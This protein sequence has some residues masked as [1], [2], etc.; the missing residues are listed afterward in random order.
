[1]TTLESGLTPALE[2][3]GSSLREARLSRGLELAQLAGQLRMG[4]EQLQALEQADQ[5]RLPELVFVI[6]QARRVATHLGVDIDP[7]VAP[8][9]R[10]GFTIKPAPAPLAGSEQQSDE[11]RP[12]RLTASQYTEA[13]ASERHRPGPLKRLAQLALLAG[14]LS[15]GTWGWQNRQRL[16]NELSWLQGRLQALTGAEPTKPSKAL[17]P[18]KPAPKPAPKP[19]ATPAAA[20]TS[21]TLSSAQPSWIEVRSLAGN[22]QLFEGDLKGRRVFP[23]G[24]GL[25]VLA[26]RP[27]LVLASLGTAPAK[28]LGPI[29]QINWI[30]FKPKAA[31]PKPAAT[32]PAPAKPAPAKPQTT[33]PAPAS[34]MAPTP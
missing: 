12:S 9:K 25:R 4:E 10:G 27:D 23:L 7:L 33:K 15:A 19:A 32:K 6:A 30:T 24:Q 29:D 21:L 17:T 16:P 1:M 26:G 28:P 31:T 13:K 3:L 8:L 14:L 2:S 18:A 5:S 34:P 11:R 22:K 20:P